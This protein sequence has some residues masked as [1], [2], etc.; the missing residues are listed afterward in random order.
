MGHPYKV[1]RMQRLVCH[2]V[3]D[4]LALVMKTMASAWRAEDRPLW[5]EEERKG[6]QGS[7]YAVSLQSLEL[8][9]VF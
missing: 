4:P 6:F 8:Q 1:L 2:S 5:V 9:G 3:L 7:S